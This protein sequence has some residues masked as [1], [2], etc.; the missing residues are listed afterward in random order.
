ME[1]VLNFLVFNSETGSL[2]STFTMLLRIAFPDVLPVQ[3][4]GASSEQSMDGREA[5]LIL[6]V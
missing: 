2:S 5:G 6:V 4:V 1:I 3:K